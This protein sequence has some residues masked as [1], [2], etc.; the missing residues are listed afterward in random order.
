MLARLESQSTS[1]PQPHL[2]PPLSRSLLRIISST[3]NRIS[4]TLYSVRPSPPLLYRIDILHPLALASDSFSMLLNLHSQIPLHPAAPRP[5]RLADRQP[6]DPSPATQKT[7]KREQNLEVH[8]STQ[9]GSRAQ[10][11]NRQARER[12]QGQFSRFMDVSCPSPREHRR[13]KLAFLGC[14]EVAR[15]RETGGT[16]AEHFFLGAL[17]PILLGS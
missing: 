2:F 14:R 1:S 3:T 9:H 6:P 12:S 13:P 17:R 7:Y 10:P 5:R 15:G 4:L 8:P 16:C 11:V